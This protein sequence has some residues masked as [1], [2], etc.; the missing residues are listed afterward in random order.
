MTTSPSGYA[1]VIFDLDGVI[2]DTEHLWEQSWTASAKGRG[3]AWTAED[4][5]T[6]QGMSA[7]EWARYLAER[8]GAPER[9]DEVEDEC[10]QFM[11]DKVLGGEGPL[12]DGA[13]ELVTTVAEL[14]PIAVASSAPRR[15]ISAVLAEHGLADRF[16]ALCSSEEV[17]RGKPAPDV[18]LEAARR[19]GLDPARGFGIEDSSNGM[20]AAHAA[21]LTLVALP[22]R[23]YPPKPD[24][25][26][27]AEF[28]ADDHA[29]ARDF[30]VGR[31]SEGARR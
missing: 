23:V 22:N 6:V 19:L 20:R 25:L 4:T 16:S 15:L 29:K 7:P 11:I 8:V 31:L 1:G 21:G 5:T 14:V 2:V 12:L 27:L 10:V 26:A 18:Y 30:L 9:A 13:R 17:P 28:V 24:A 3:Y